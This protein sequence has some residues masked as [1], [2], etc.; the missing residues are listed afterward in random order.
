[1]AIK[2]IFCI[3]P[4]DLVE[5]QIKYS[6]SFFICKADLQASVQGKK[7]TAVKFSV[8]QGGKAM[9][10]TMNIYK[11]KDGRYEGRIP[12]DRDDTGKLKYQYFYART[13]KELKKK[14]LDAYKEVNSVASTCC[15]SLK[16]LSYEW[17][18]SVKLR[19]KQSSYCC[20][21]R[22]VTKHIIPYFED[23]G[24]AEID[25]AVINEFVEYELAYGRSNG[26][27]SLSV[28]MVR[29]IL[30]TLRS[31]SRYAEYK[32]NIA[33]PIRNIFIPKSERK[34]VPVLN[35]SERSK[36]QKYLLDNLTCSN[37]GILITMYSG[38]RIG[39]ICALKWGNIDLENGTV[40]IEKTV[41]RI[42]D[43]S[44]NDKKTML[45]FGDPKSAASVRDIPLPEFILKLMR[46][47][48]KDKN[49]FVLS[50]T[51]KPVEPRTMQYRFKNV[52][53]QCSIRDVNFHLLRHTYATLCIEKGFDI[54]AVSEL[55]GHTNVNITLNRYV[56]S[57]IEAKK[58]YV[59]RLNIA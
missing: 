25:T 51:K 37:L 9:R 33:D 13:V 18:D 38:L 10:S 30:S 47:N 16:E 12:V 40:H 35:D 15:K 45:H 7:N 48:V 19:V 50:G 41:Q 49:C 59:E 2:N 52:L 5:Y 31:I 6:T 56:H 21:E 20:Y 44:E 4:N 1:M 24:Y 54:K 53:K 34:T 32:Y 28:K 43:R 17:L 42:T 58:R 23:I 46:E 22:I 29:D 26:V 36:L 3:K 55:L 8:N 27:G 14:M 39:E 57:S 11:R